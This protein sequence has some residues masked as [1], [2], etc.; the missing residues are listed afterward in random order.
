MNGTPAT[1][2]PVGKPFIARPR[3][4]VSLPATARFTQ[5]RNA[6]S[7]ALQIL[8]LAKFIVWSP[9]RASDTASPGQ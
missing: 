4:R 2:N 5:F 9:L 7:L 1:V 6:D 8:N 3:F